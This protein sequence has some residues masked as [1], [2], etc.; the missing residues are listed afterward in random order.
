MEG[1]NRNFSLNIGDIVRP[2]STGFLNDA[3]WN[4]YFERNTKTK[5]K[6]L[7]FYEASGEMPTCRGF[8]EYVSTFLIN[9]VSQCFVDLSSNKH[10]VKVPSRRWS[11]KHCCN[12]SQAL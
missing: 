2:I 12:A 10:A 9:S 7:P 5:R 8:T 4:K 3:F 6:C 1:K 11:G